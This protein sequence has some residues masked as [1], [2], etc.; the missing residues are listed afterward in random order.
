MRYIDDP[1]EIPLFEISQLRLKAFWELVLCCFAHKDARYEINKK[2]KTSVKVLHI[3]EMPTSL[4]ELDSILSNF[5]VVMHFDIGKEGLI[6]QFACEEEFCEK[7]SAIISKE[8]PYLTTR[9]ESIL[10]DIKKLVFSS[11]VVKRKCRTIYLL[12]FMDFCG[13]YQFGDLIINFGKPGNNVSGKLCLCE[14]PYEIVCIPR[15]NLVKS[16]SIDNAFEVEEQYK[17]LLQFIIRAPLEEINISSLD[18]NP[19]EKMFECGK[20]NEYNEDLNLKSI[21]SYTSIDRNQLGLPSYLHNVVESF[22]CLSPKMRSVF[23]DSCSMYAKALTASPNDAVTSFVIVL[24]NLCKYL[25]PNIKRSSDRFQ[26]IYDEFYEPLSRFDKSWERFYAVRCAYA[27]DAI[28]FQNSFERVLYEN[29]ASKEDVVFLEKL[30]FF[31]MISWLKRKIDE[32]K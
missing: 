1:H 16:P 26:K 11:P 9:I 22:D 13:E 14:F 28:V 32:S 31:A 23:L 18:L 6:F 8:L 4:V 27:H 15:N 20:G 3:L 29:I 12:R 10:L 5:Y 19:V 25:Y 24:E 30:T 2:A 7:H 21:I 17:Q